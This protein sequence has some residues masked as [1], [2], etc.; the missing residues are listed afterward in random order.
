MKLLLTNDDGIDAPGIAALLEAA[1]HVGDPLVVAPLE[2]QSGCSHRVTTGRPLRVLP[3]PP[4]GFAVDG[5]PADC[6]RV[7]LS[8]LAPETAC[9]LSGI[10][11]GGNL[12]ADVYISGTVAAV[13]EAVLHGWRG[14][15]VSQY[16]RRNAAI[17]WSVSAR[18]V[19]PVLRQLLAEPWQPGVFWNVNLPH[20]E[21]GAADPEVIYCPLDP[22]PLPLSYRSDGDSLHYDGNYHERQRKPGSDVDICFR[23]HIAV[24]R[25]E[26]F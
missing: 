20:L 16:H 23:G 22:S 14:I 21:A 17:D 3:R 7:G 18:W 12:G 8:R 26:L 15:A 13:R 9:V 1:R 4:L 24:T 2:H 19:V 10:N 6:V 25:F 11:E 5:L